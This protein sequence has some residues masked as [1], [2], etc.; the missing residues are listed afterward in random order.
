VVEGVITGTAFDFLATT[1]LWVNFGVTRRELKE[2]PPGKKRK[3]THSFDYIWGGG[4]ATTEG[5]GWCKSDLGVEAN[6]VEQ[7]RHKPSTGGGGGGVEVR[8]G[9]DQ[10]VKE[11]AIL[12]YVSLKEG[13]DP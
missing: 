12:W 2:E 9:G 7:N 4:R 5:W 11:D 13:G 8:G 10:W 3:R 6:G 1:S